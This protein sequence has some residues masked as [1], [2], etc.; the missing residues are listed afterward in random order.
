MSS[1]EECTIEGCGCHQQGSNKRP[2]N[3]YDMKTNLRHHH[4]KRRF[5]PRKKEQYIKEHSHKGK[6]ILKRGADFHNLL[7]EENRN[8]DATPNKGQKGEINPI[9]KLNANTTYGIDAP[10]HA[11]GQSQR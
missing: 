4:G 5:P 10:Y 3:F 2:Y 9:T 8:Q 6:Y 11:V 7:H 1:S